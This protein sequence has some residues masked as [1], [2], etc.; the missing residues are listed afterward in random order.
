MYVKAVQQPKFVI[1]FSHGNAID[2]GQMS[3]FYLS[4]GTR[5]NCNIF[6]LVRLFVC[7]SK[8]IHYDLSIVNFSRNSYDYSGY[9]VSSGR[10][11]ERNLYADIECAWNTLRNKYNFEPSQIILYGQSIGTVPTVDLAS[12][13]EVAA[14]I[15]H[16]PL[17]SGFR[18]FTVN[19]LKKNIFL[20]K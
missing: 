11:S 12:R 1:L 17:M 14:V 6:R 20:A 10:A 3:S 13:F 16:S 15:L 18:I 7:F 5:I 4:L 2:L 8:Q 19:L 9:G